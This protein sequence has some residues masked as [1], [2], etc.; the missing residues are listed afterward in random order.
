MALLFH[1]LAAQ[2]TAAA[3]RKSAAR[4]TLVAVPRPSSTNMAKLRFADWW[5]G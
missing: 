2:S 4:S 5:L 3:V 1:T